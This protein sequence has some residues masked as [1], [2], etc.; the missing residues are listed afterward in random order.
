MNTE[1]ACLNTTLTH[2]TRMAKRVDNVFMKSKFS[3]AILG[4]KMPWHSVSEEGPALV[5]PWRFST[6]GSMSYWGVSVVLIHVW[7]LAFF[8]AC[9]YSLDL[10]AYKVTD[11]IMLLFECFLDHTACCMA[12]S[13]KPLL[14]RLDDV[15]WP[16]YMLGFKLKFVVCM[17]AWIM[18]MLVWQPAWYFLLTDWV[19]LWYDG[20]DY[21][22]VGKL[23]PTVH[24]LRLVY[25][26]TL[27]T[28]S[29]IWI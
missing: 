11:L 10:T 1:L 6:K 28:V 24:L 16:C 22:S 7:R 9:C 2:V 5:C 17:T 26:C 25:C 14:D 23:T 3:V 18:L 27:S 8:S 21:T 12:V 13:M 29:V 4:Q 20:L 19:L 15:V